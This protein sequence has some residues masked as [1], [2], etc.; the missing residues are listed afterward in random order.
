M[1][2]IGCLGDILFEVT[3]DKIMTPS[4]FS[5][6]G[7]AS[8]TTHD[9]HLTNAMTEF[10]GLAPDT[11]SLEVTLSMYLGV[12]PMESLVKLWTYE[13]NGR[14]LP[15][16]IGNKAYGKYRWTI[17]SHTMKAQDFLKDGTVSSATVSI[18]LQE[19]LKS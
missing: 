8:Y 10:T 14:A 5:W 13:R 7:S 1:A 9:R 12:D 3:Q 16:T 17:T 15:L 4:S 11:I 2:T 19:Y 18:S 6:S